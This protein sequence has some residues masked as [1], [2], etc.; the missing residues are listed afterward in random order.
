MNEDDNYFNCP[1]CSHYFDHEE[2]DN[3]PNCHTKVEDDE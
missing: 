3:C 1:V 2:Y